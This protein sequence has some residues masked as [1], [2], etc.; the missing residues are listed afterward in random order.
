MENIYQFIANEEDMLVGR[1]VM[2]NEDI[3]APSLHPQPEVMDL[4]DEEA[5]PPPLAHQDAFVLWNRPVSDDED[6]AD[7]DEQGKQP[8]N[9]WG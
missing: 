5:C 1:E 9:V 6:E 7:V 2:E 8:D 3:L 4:E